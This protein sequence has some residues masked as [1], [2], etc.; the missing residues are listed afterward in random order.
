[1]T[2]PGG[3]EVKK[4]PANAG[5]WV[6]KIPWSRKWQPTPGFL[7]GESHGQ[8]SLVGYS[9]QGHKE[10]KTN[11]HACMHDHLWWERGCRLQ[12][13]D[14]LKFLGHLRP[15]SW[16]H[17]QQVTVWFW[18]GFAI[19]EDVSVR[20][21]WASHR[22]LMC[23]WSRALISCWNPGISLHFM[24]LLDGHSHSCKITLFTTS[25]QSNWQQYHAWNVFTINDF[26]KWIPLMK[27][28]GL[29]N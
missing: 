24:L 1:M 18:P 27:M 8:R 11:E 25:V 21:G 2:F 14:V 20:E 12:C 17:D 22:N 10:L 16:G 15:S 28:S 7:P 13:L 5:D 29:L 4:L 6:G 3:S 26:L 19:S 23:F 9:P